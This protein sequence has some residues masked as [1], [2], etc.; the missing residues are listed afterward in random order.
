MLRITDK[1]APEVIAYLA[2]K[3]SK[4]TTPAEAKGDKIVLDIIQ[5]GIDQANKL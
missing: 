1:L 2:S 5:K 4:A 3:G